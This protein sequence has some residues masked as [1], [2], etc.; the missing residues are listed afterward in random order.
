M[1]AMHYW[2]NPFVLFEPKLPPTMNATLEDT[3]DPKVHAGN[4]RRMLTEVVDHLRSDIEKIE[5]PKAQALFETSAE[6]LIGVRTAFEHYSA[7][8]EKAW[9]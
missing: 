4:I 3:S 8:S 9:K 7:G 2:I 5:E 1:Q 6:V